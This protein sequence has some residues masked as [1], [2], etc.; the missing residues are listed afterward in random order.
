[1]ASLLSRKEETTSDALLIAEMDG[2][3]EM[4]LTNRL[5]GAIVNTKIIPDVDPLQGK[6]L[7]LFIEVEADQFRVG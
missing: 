4:K 3:K 5:H 6:E 7:Q 1:M 2:G